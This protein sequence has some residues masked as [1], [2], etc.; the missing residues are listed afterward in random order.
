MKATKVRP[1]PSGVTKQQLGGHLKFSQL[2]VD[3]TGQMFLQCSSSS[4]QRVMVRS[5]HGD[6]R[7]VKAQ[8]VDGVLHLRSDASCDFDCAS[9]LEWTVYSRPLDAITIRGP[10]HLESLVTLRRR[11]RIEIF[12]RG[13]TCRRHRRLLS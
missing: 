6:R 4:R 11:Y 5:R 9:R 1:S 8:L 2:D 12:Y 7:K 10:V 3:V 13:T